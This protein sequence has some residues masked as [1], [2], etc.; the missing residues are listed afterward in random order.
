[1][2]YEMNEFKRKDLKFSIDGIG[3][4]FGLERD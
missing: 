4:I 3:L 1:M 2:K